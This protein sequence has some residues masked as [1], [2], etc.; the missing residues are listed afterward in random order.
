MALAEKL[1]DFNRIDE[2]NSALELANQARMTEEISVPLLAIQHKIENLG[3][4]SKKL[5]GLQKYPNLDRDAKNAM[6]GSI[7]KDILDSYKSQFEISLRKIQ[8][9][10]NAT[11]SKTKDRAGCITQAQE[12][13]QDVFMEYGE[14]DCLDSVK[15]Q[16]ESYLKLS[17][18]YE[19]ILSKFKPHESNYR[20]DLQGRDM[21]KILFFPSK[22]EESLKIENEQMA[23]VITKLL[24]KYKEMIQSNDHLKLA[25]TTLRAELA[26]MYDY[27][28]ELLEKVLDENDTLGEWY[29]KEVEENIGLTVEL[30]KSQEN[31]GVLTIENE[32][33]KQGFLSLYEKYNGQLDDMDFLNE[34]MKSEIIDM[35][36][37]TQLENETKAGRMKKIISILNQKNLLSR[38]Q[39]ADFTNKIQQLEQENKKITEKN[40]V[41]QYELE[42]QSFITNV[43]ETG[44]RSLEIEFS[45][46]EPL[47]QKALADYR[48][49][50][51]NHGITGQELEKAQARIQDLE[52]KV[53]ELQTRRVVMN[54]NI[55]PGH[56]IEDYENLN[57]KYRTLQEYTAI[58]KLQFFEFNE[59][60]ASL[61]SEI[62]QKNELIA[63]LNLSHKNKD[64]IF[65]A[66]TLFIAKL[67]AQLAKA[68]KERGVTDMLLQNSNEE[69]S[70]LRSQIHDLE[71]KLSLLNTVD[72][73]SDYTPEDISNYDA[74]TKELNRLQL[75]LDGLNRLEEYYESVQNQL[76][77]SRQLNKQLKLLAES[78]QRQFDESEG[79]NEGLQ[80]LLDGSYDEIEASTKQIIETA[81]ALNIETK[82]MTATDLLVLIKTA[83]LEYLDTNSCITRLKIVMQ[84]EIPKS[85]NAVSFDTLLSNDESRENLE[86]VLTKLKN[87]T[88][89]V[90][91]LEEFYACLKI[92]PEFIPNFAVVV[93]LLSKNQA[94]NFISVISNNI[95]DAFEKKIAEYDLKKSQ[96][97]AD[98]LSTETENLR[99][100]IKD[101]TQENIDSQISF[102]TQMT[103]NMIQIDIIIKELQGRYNKELTEEEKKDY[104]AFFAYEPKENPKT[105][106]WKLLNEVKEELRADIKDDSSGA[107]E[108][109][110]KNE[111]DKVL[112]KN[113]EEDQAEASLTNIIDTGEGEN[114]SDEAFSKNGEEAQDIEASLRDIE[115]HHKESWEMVT[116]DYEGEF[117]FYHMSKKS[118]DQ[119]MLEKTMFHFFPDSKNIQTYIK[120]NKLEDLLKFYQESKAEIAGKKSSFDK[121][122]IE[123]EKMICKELEK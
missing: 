99:E 120:E 98:D 108:V 11:L 104:P 71:V 100:K 111:P 77:A 3:I 112:S 16:F 118:N 4:V 115:T 25:N 48:R 86:K 91:S 47:Y 53:K 26:E 78:F 10:M 49:E 82:D 42:N 76:R 70:H 94:W 15:K 35:Q 85:L 74:L 95:A 62:D 109:D 17:Y 27:A 6:I 52:Q 88:S 30:K 97:T 54:E 113:S 63:E 68:D 7:K 12:L 23:K 33:L 24:E 50:L 72:R 122:L 101:V 66:M 43:F 105:Y 59:R 41:T 20:L 36:M 8:N 79:D 89:G 13:A 58:L 55:I 40:E 18:L 51:Q 9:N 81:K 19:D 106:F 5:A 90:E 14:F 103:E 84:D 1:D 56:T 69:N 110:G 92:N 29:K 93:E 75:Q 116:K 121:K 117:G 22:L 123:L 119:I 60:F 67:K 83:S 31:E 65:I 46:M 21:S 114:E 37:L 2:L 73:V 57:E 96:K 28:S 32:A 39:I 80:K 64:Q 45:T 44:F 107:K 38:D 61:R 34:L 102:Y 87:N